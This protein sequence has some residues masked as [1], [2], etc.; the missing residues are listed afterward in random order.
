MIGFI[1]TTVQ[2]PNDRDFMLWVYGEFRN[3][4][5]ATA[6]KYTS[7]PDDADDI[8]QEA[9]V[10]LIRKVDTLRPMKRH[11]LA[12]YIIATIRNRAINE[13]KSRAY[14]K[15]N[16]TDYLES[17]TSEGSSLDELMILA[18]QR[19]QLGKIWNR[20]SEEDRFLLEGRYILGCTD[21]ELAE[22]L[23]C[24]PNSIR[25]KL[26]RARRNALAFL[27]EEGGDCYE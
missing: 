19:A 24:K 5:Y 10:S 17:A 22:S 2:D 8:V 26:T 15:E 12:G 23:C 13:L 14:Q 6:Y 3:L 9:L 1:Y 16:T 11:I 27:L 7:E 18:E 25:M 4:M 21:Q 20:L